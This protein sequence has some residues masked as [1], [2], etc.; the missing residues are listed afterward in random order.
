M[1]LV[2]R[3]Y[4]YLQDEDRLELLAHFQSS[5]PKH[6]LCYQCYIFHR[7]SGI[8]GA[9][10]LDCGRRNGHLVTGTMRLSFSVMQNAMNCYLYGRS[11]YVPFIPFT[12]HGR[13]TKYDITVEEKVELKASNDNVLLHQRIIAT[14]N[15]TGLQVTTKT[16][17]DIPFNVPLNKW[18]FL[19]CRVCETDIGTRRDR[20]DANYDNITVD[21]WRALGPC[22]SPF[23]S[24]WELQTE[25]YDRYH[26]PLL[27][28]S[29]NEFAFS[30]FRE[31]KPL[32]V[33]S[34]SS[35]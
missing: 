22:R 28:T 1:D 32:S 2:G 11:H 6:L 24:Q 21:L 23:E 7:K 15:R 19:K 13:K 33:P 16:A 4:L 9:G 30:L 18:E 20:L 17:K 12:Y 10:S 3:Q 29:G 35:R 8:L 26:K 31:T 27:L 5:F 34:G 25:P 14:F